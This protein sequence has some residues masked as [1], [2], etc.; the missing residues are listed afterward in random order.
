MGTVQG[1]TKERMLEIEANSVVSGAI[2]VPTGHLKLTQHDGDV[3]DAGKVV[4]DSFGDATTAAKG[5]AMLATQTEVNAGTDPNK[6]VTPLT[7]AT[8]LA[9]R[10]ALKKDILPSAFATGDDL[11][12]FIT[13]DVRITNSNT[14]AATLL[15]LPEPYAGFLEVIASSTI[16]Y[17]RWTTYTL[18]SGAGGGDRIWTRGR[19]SAGVWSAWKRMAIVNDTWTTVTLKTGYADYGVLAGAPDFK[20][21]RYKIEN[22][23]GEMLSGWVGRSVTASI[24][25]GTLYLDSMFDALPAGSRPDQVVI[26]MGELSTP[27]AKSYVQYRI[28]PDGKIGWL[29]PVAN[30]FATTSASSMW[31]PGLRWK[32]A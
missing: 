4:P 1:L 24:G 9:D 20:L 31:L 3:I 25:A 14:T 5:V 6:I 7:F 29:S 11:N 8:R 18:S 13:T 19:T 16:I 10:L 32:L 17:Q 30:S 27:T 21:P 22:G 2:D 28:Y 23:M 15:N 12:N 26:G